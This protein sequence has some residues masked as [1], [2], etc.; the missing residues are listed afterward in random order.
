MSHSCYMYENALAQLIQHVV[1]K[2]IMNNNIC[3]DEVQYLEIYTVS[4]GQC[5]I[6]LE[7]A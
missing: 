3:E 7:T 5:S 2:A 1:C 6:V 4:K